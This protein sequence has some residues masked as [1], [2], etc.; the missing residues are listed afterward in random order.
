[1]R[2]IH[3]VL[4]SYLFDA[5]DRWIPLPENTCIWLPNATASRIEN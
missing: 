3:Q 1:M 4:S 2:D 5:L